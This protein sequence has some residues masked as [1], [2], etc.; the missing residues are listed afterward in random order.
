VDALVF[1]GGIGENAV[2]VR[3][4]IVRRLAVLGVAAAEAERGGD[5]ILT[6]GPPALLRVHAREDLVIADAADDLL[7]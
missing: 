1:T 2:P 4:R 3:E 5:A 7:A 6:P